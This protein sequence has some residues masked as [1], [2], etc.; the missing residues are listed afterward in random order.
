MYAGGFRDMVEG[1]SKSFGI[2]ANAISWKN[3]LLI[4]CWVFGSV[5][6]TRHFI[7]SV[8]LGDTVD[9]YIWSGLYVLYFIQ[10]Y[11]MLFHVGNYGIWPALFFPLPVLFFVLV[12][13]ISLFKTTFLKKAHWKGRTVSTRK[14]KE[15][16]P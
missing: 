9:L 6:L 1:F 4:V 5:S 11:W 2:G 8:L 14:D 15:A 3:L 10:I 7:Q 12:F 16:G 13:C